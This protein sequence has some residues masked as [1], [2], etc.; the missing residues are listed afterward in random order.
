[1]IKHDSAGCK[2]PDHG[3]SVNIRPLDGTIKSPDFCIFDPN[4]AR[5]VGTSDINAAAKDACPTIIWEIGLSESARKLGRDCAR[6][7][8]GSE[9]RVNLALGTKIYSEKSNKSDPPRGQS[10]STVRKFTEKDKKATPEQ[11]GKLRRLDNKENKG[12]NVPLA[13]RYLF[14]VNYG[15]FISTWKVGR[16]LTT[17]SF[18]KHLVRLE[19]F[20]AALPLFRSMAQASPSLP[21]G[22]SKF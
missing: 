6:F 2:T 13:R 14:S 19:I 12:K 5:G 18:C 11:C 7:S 21:K 16:K 3:G 20:E 10:K 8:R 1:M 9:G 4:L 22:P 17:V 15:A